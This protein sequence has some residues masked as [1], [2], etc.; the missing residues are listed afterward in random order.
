MIDPL[1]AAGPH[2][3]TGSLRALAVTTPQRNHRFGHPDANRRRVPA[4]ISRA[5]AACSRPPAS[6]RAIVQS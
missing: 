3:K 1:A 2:I 4:T 5:G 6:P